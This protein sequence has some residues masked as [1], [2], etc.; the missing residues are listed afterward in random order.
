MAQRIALQLMFLAAHAAISVFQTA[1]VDLLTRSREDPATMPLD[2][3]MR[4]LELRHAQNAVVSLSLFLRS[5]LTSEEPK[6]AAR[7][8]PPPFFNSFYHFHH[9]S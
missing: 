9:L 4:I 2:A 6:R 3:L 1:S 7:S 8:C 5:I